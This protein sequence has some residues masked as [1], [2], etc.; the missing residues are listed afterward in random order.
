MTRATQKPVVRVVVGGD[1]R[2]GRQELVAEVRDR[3]LTLRPVRTRREGPQEVT[4]P[5]GAIYLRAMV[6]RV[7][8]E[9]RVKGKRKR[10]RR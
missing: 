1:D 2:L 9:R 3:V 7:E 8:E 4:V 10:R 5:W 6:A